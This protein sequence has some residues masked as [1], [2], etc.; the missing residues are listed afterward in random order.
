MFVCPRCN[1]IVLGATEFISHVK[2]IHNFN[3]INLAQ[4]ICPYS[5]CNVPIA[6]WSGFIRHLKSHDLM[7]DLNFNFESN[8][9]YP[10]LESGSRLLNDNLYENFNELENLD[11]FRNISIETGIEIVGNVLG[12]FCS[13]LSANGVTN[14]E[15]DFIAK[16]M[17]YAVHEIIDLINK[18]GKQTFN[19]QENFDL[20]S[21]QIKSLLSSFGKVRT[22][23]QRQKL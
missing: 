1:K 6:S 22:G 16:Q 3:H 12:E 9:N 10:K 23:Y 15:L 14:S 17:E 8:E 7:A 5:T 18:L 4:L 21:S 20:F 2:Y 19:K 11:N 13:S